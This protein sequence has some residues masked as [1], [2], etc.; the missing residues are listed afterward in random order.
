MKK[1]R[2]TPSVGPIMAKRQNLSSMGQGIGHTDNAGKTSAF[3]VGG[4]AG[5]GGV[6]R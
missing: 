5:A 1:T 2:H 6:S 3:G 4:Y